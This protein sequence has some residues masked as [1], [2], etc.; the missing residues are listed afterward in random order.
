MQ[1]NASYLASPEFLQ[2]AL[3]AL[4][5]ANEEHVQHH[6]EAAEEIL[7]SI[8]QAIIV[9]EVAIQAGDADTED[10]QDNTIHDLVEE[11]EGH[12]YE[13]QES[14]DVIAMIDSYQ[15]DPSKLIDAIKAFPFD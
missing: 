9:R 14:T 13:V 8:L 3:P 11:I 1:F 10:L 6:T 7:G 12:L 15:S 5:A 4:K 2:S